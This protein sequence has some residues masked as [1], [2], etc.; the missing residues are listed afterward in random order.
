[1]TFSAWT[2]ARN[3]YFCAELK[4]SN[5]EL[6]QRLEVTA[7]ERES[8]LGTIKRMDA[9]LQALRTHTHQ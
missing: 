8:F 5:L 2:Y 9:E 7:T 6:S 3:E 4:A 1:M